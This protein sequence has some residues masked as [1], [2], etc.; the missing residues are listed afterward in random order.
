MNV[1]QEHL[2]TIKRNKSKLIDCTT[3]DT[4]GVKKTKHY[5]DTCRND[6]I[7]RENNLL[8]EKLLSLT[9][10]R[11]RSRKLTSNKSGYF[12]PK[13]M[14]ISRRRRDEEKIASE[15]KALASR[16][17]SISPSLK[18]KNAEKDYEYH[19][20]YR[21]NVC[22]FDVI[23]KSTIKRVRLDS[24]NHFTSQRTLV[25]EHKSYMK[26]PY[27][28]DSQPALRKEWKIAE[29]TTAFNRNYMMAVPIALTPSL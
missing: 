15:N 24:L 2:K 28:E 18:R 14:N 26:N 5:K 3:P 10:N 8:L 6:E 23:E 11:E 29:I 21:K 1:H 27:L 4:Y 7:F 20:K 13:S 22:K 19:K 12:N 9:E 16:L 17:A 25:S